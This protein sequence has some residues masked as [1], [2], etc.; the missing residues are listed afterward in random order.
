MRLMRWIFFI[1]SASGASRGAHADPLRLGPFETPTP[2]EL[3]IPVADQSFDL[4]QA[5][6]GSF[7]SPEHCARVP[8]GLWVEVS[9]K[10]DCIR[11][12]AHGLSQDGNPGALIYFG[13]DVMLRT[14]KGVR[15]IS[16]AYGKQS[17]STIEADLK[18]WSEQAGWPAIYVARPGIYGSSG[19]HNMRR[20]PREI[21]LMDRAVDLIKERHKIS[22]FILTGHS[23]GGQIA[24]GLLNK[25]KDI[26]AAVITSGFLSAKQIASY[27]ERRRAIPGKLLYDSSQFYDPVAGIKSIENNPRPEIYIISDP[28]D[29]VI[30]FSSQLFYVRKLRQAGFKPQHIYAHAP[31]R[32]RHLLAQNGKLAASLIARGESE[33]SIRRALNEF[34]LDQIESIS[35]RDR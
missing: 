13:G 9:G 5:L 31:D 34:E 17:P 32:Q 28:E 27:W 33:K 26:S 21:E 16:G 6:H 10:G 11:Y 22:S 7:S 25:R 23:A 2:Q 35:A 1:L 19:D 3:A 15:F 18:E 4:Y 24:A 20:Y 12:Y 30:P 8:N 14:S 29:R